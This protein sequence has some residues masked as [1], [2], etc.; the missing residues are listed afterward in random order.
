[1]TYNASKQELAVLGSP[2]QQTAAK[3]IA[4][5]RLMKN[6][7]LVNVH[8]LLLPFRPVNCLKA[9]KTLFFEDYPYVA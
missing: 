6:C 1:M 5:D 4:L 9:V 7:S 3:I 8:G 2:E